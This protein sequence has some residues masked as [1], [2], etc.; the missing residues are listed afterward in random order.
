[1]NFLELYKYKNDYWFWIYDLKT[2]SQWK[3]NLCYFIKF[4][5][6]EKIKDKR[7]DNL[8]LEILL[9]IKEVTKIKLKNNLNIL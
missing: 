9:K 2:Q 3:K 1:M 8:V 7:T 4:V 6:F 5:D